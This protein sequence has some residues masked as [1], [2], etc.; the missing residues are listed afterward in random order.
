MF[1][2]AFRSGSFRLG[3]IRLGPKGMYSQIYFY[4]DLKFFFCCFYMKAEQADDLQPVG[5]CVQF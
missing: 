1:L 2:M 5:R 3:P 4:S